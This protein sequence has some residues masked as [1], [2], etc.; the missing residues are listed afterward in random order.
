M[1]NKATDLGPVE[2]GKNLDA[3]GFTRPAK[4]LLG[5]S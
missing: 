5:G 3:D 2:F 1:L 4:G